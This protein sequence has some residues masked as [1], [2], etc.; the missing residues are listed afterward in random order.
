M[1]E[2]VADLQIVIEAALL[3]Y[4]PQCQHPGAKG[5]D[6]ALHYAVFPG[7]KRIRPTLSILGAK[8][9]GADPGLALP[10]ACAVEFTH[11]SSLIFDDLPCMDDA[12]IRRGIPV[13][14]HV[15]GEEVALLAGIALLNQSYAIYGQTPELIAEATRCIGVHG[16]VVGQALDL[17]SQDG[18]GEPIDEWEKRQAERNRKTSAMMRLALTAGAL[19][20]G[21]E[22]AEVAPL[23]AAGQ[24]IGEAYQ[25]AD[26]LLDGEKSRTRAEKTPGQNGCH[27]LIQGTTGEQ[28]SLDQID[29][30]LE[31]ARFS[32]HEAYG[33]AT[34][35]ELMA[36]VDAIFAAFGPR[37][38]MAS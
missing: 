32:L 18:S 38:R 33:A 14:H 35:A 19:A 3:S 25:I 12:Q 13:L 15:F 10:A 24:S 21:A 5:L 29:G 22:P 17:L 1:P 9:L 37:K 16:M 20:C 30:L 27:R 11:T 8:V 31:H 2:S 23:G 36:S 6:N 4:L 7:G 28:A 26:D 34:V